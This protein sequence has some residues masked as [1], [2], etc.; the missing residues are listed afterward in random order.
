MLKKFIMFFELLLEKKEEVYNVKLIW[1][2]SFL[3]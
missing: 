3:W 1:A 2:T